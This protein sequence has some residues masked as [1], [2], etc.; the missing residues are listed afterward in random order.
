MKGVV[1]VGGGITGLLSVIMLKDHYELVYLI[2][3]EEK[4]GGL[5]RSVVNEDGVYFDMGTHIPVETLVNEVDDILFEEM[6]NEE[7]FKLP[8]L[9]VGNVFKG[10][11]YDKSPYVY[12]PYMEESRYNKGLAQLL[13]CTDGELDTSNLETYSNGYFGETF[14]KDIFEPLMKKLLG[15]SLDR[16]HPSAL[17][18]FNYTRLIVGDTSMSR[19]LKKSSIYNEKLAYASFNEGI[20]PNRKYYPKKRKGVELWVEQLVSKAEQ[21]G[22]RFLNSTTIVDVKH[23]NNEI[24]K[25]ILQDGTIIETDLVVW[26]TAPANLL[27]IADI[28]L[29]SKPP[30]FRKMTL[31]NYVFDM[32]FLTD[33]HYIYCT[34]ESVN[35]FRVTIYPNITPSVEQSAPYNCTVEVLT[36]QDANVLALNE[37][38][39][40]ELRDMGIITTEAIVLS[41]S[42]I[43]IKNGFPILTNNF[44]NAVQAQ[45]EIVRDRLKNVVLVGKASGEVFFLNEAAIDTYHK[46]KE[47]ISKRGYLPND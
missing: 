45:R 22:V 44:I 19:E 11:L 27:R 41:K 29:G 34:D 14:T 16:L 35:S 38:I 25:V 28:P 46:I 15:E 4:C 33:N 30:K 23:E 31:H 20:S 24:N 9:E 47:I 17:N 12:T 10:K 32:P 7:W 42:Y 13:A 1:V 5:L 6:K 39:I 26:T 40:E 36:D 2:E 43:E 21:K 37:N 8:N 3:R 18:L